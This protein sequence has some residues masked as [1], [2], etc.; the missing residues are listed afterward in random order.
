MSL[1]QGVK[2]PKSKKNTKLGSV[3]Y[4]IVLRVGYTLAPVHLFSLFF[5]QVLL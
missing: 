5:R 4:C 3:V 2:T 1:F